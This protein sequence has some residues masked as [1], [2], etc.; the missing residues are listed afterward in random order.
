MSSPA[1]NGQADDGTLTSTSTSTE[2][3]GI[4]ASSQQQIIVVTA[5]T[6]LTVG[7]F[8]ALMGIARWWFR[9]A[10]IQYNDN[11]YFIR[12]SPRPWRRASE[13]FLSVTEMRR[14]RTLVFI[15]KP[16]VTDLKLKHA[17][18]E[19]TLHWTKMQV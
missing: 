4:D 17:Q 19:E 6:V 16:S 18:N 13:R 14:L 11:E 7:G 1:L 3:P 5:F 8:M 2:H 10:G 9:R 12:S 15:S